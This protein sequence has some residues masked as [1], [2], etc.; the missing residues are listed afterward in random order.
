MALRIAVLSMLEVAGENA[1]MP[2]AFLRIGPAS[3]AR[4]Q[5]S[6]ALAME[7]QRIVC[8]ARAMSAELVALQLEAER[9]GAR[10]HCINGPRGLAGLVTATDEVL[11]ITDGLLVPLDA[12][13]GLL[14]GGH[15]VLVQPVEA[16]VAAGFERIDLSHAAAGLTRI[17]GR[18]VERL[19][20]LPADCDAASALTRIA[21]QSGIE[22]RHLPP[23]TREGLRWRLVHTEAEAHAAEAGWIGAHLNDGGPQTPGTALARLAVRGFGPAILHAGRGGNTLAIA[24]ALV[25]LLALGLGW[26][27]IA[28]TA[29]VL[30]GVAW[31]VRRA[32]ALL[33]AVEDESLGKPPS[34]WPRESLFDWV[35]DAA[36]LSVLVWNTAPFSGASL[37]QRLFAPLILLCLIRLLSRLAERAWA[38]WLGDRLLLGILLALGGAAGMLAQAIPVAAMGLA[39][40]AIVLPSGLMRIT[41]V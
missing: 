1:A 22:Q 6:L 28:A 38:G 41:R 24:A 3:L 39:L 25:V 5:L 36:I 20:E 21:L 19:Q 11:V 23:E 32:A 9:A 12:A 27:G 30:C 40:L 17:P 2:R 15:V 16:G 29:L 14:E 13:L 26:F 10:F 7:C 31:L 4:H 18:L 35:N 8:I 33:I 34:R 37:W